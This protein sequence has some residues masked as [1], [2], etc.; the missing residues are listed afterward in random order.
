MIPNDRLIQ[1][2]PYHLKIQKYHDNIKN[3]HQEQQQKKE[4]VY[5]MKD[6]KKN[7]R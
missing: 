4:N 6:E 7:G 3:Y 2:I 1:K 5:I